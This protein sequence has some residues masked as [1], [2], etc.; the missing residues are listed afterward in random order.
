MGPAVGQVAKLL[1]KPFMPW[2]QL[3]AD[4]VLEVDTRTGLLVYQEFGLTVP[5]QSGKAL[6]VETP[7]LTGRGWVAMGDVR[8]GD[9]VFHPGGHLTTVVAVSPVMVDHP[10]YQVTTTDGRSVVADG[11]HLWTVMDKRL[12]RSVGP[13]GVR[14]RHYETVTITTAQMALGVSR[15]RLGSRTSM[16]SGVAYST[17][18]YR[19]RLP[20]QEPLKSDD[21]ELPVDPYL[22][23]AWLGDG[24]SAAAALTCHVDDAPHWVRVVAAAGYVPS[25]HP[26]VRGVCVGITATPGVGRHARSF[27]GWLRRAGL[28]GDKHIPDLFLTAGSAQREA[29]LQ[30]LLDTDGHCAPNGNIEFCS[31]RRE[32]AT[33]VLFLARS[34]GWRSTLREDR[35]RLNGVDCGPRYRV[36]FTAKPSD[37]FSPFRMRRK[38]SQV[39]G[40]G[41][42]KGRFTVAV[43][44]VEP[45]ASRP[46]R[47]LTVDSPDGLYLA[48]RDLIVTHNSTFVLSKA[49]HRGT[50]SKFFG[51]RQRMVYTAQTRK[52]ARE[53][54]EEDFAPDI[55]ASS[56]LRN[57]IAMHWGSG[58][59]H[60]RF[61]NGSRFGL[62]STTEKS[63][64]GG[65][66]DEADMDEA[67]ALP[68][69]RAEQAFRP[70]MIT[71]PNTQLGWI[72]TAGWL[73][74]SP[75]LESKVA[76]GRAAVDSGARS[77]LAY[78]EWSAPD[79]CDPDDPE[80]W[81]ACM[82]ALGY[83]I[84]QE[85]IAYEFS[86]MDLAEF[87][88]AYLNIW[89]PKPAAVAGHVRDRLRQVEGAGRPG[90]AVWREP[91]MSGGGHHTGPCGGER[92]RCWCQS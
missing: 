49:I 2:Q 81:R 31:T 79:D 40:G 52:D 51:S 33:G 56:V 14:V 70:A 36:C 43:K 63:G 54:W 60:M 46:V 84:S 69:S 76:K 71:R 74:G 59:E 10:C 78:F 24:T 62:E 64:H 16:T 73:D 4:V 44:T 86:A 20:V 29:L 75:Y 23:G 11:E 1:G 50:A 28:W 77:G 22:F 45:V 13:R 48:G 37:P 39:T 9:R 8:P 68:D 15:Y 12:E 26:R 17:N 82:P 21:V 55:E 57:R 34:L 67:F 30:G 72:S 88:R 42:G 38:A 18:E 91:H 7:I 19:Y 83:T 80:V 47:C 87:Q 53:K 58:R 61:P 66:L 6:D 89:V 27:R 25:V 65:I 5:R 3:V 35:A 85:S 92:R 90:L 32:L 41:G